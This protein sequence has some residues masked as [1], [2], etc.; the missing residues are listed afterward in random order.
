MQL[1]RRRSRNHRNGSA[2]IIAH[3]R[4]TKETREFRERYES[5]SELELKSFAETFK[6]QRVFYRNFAERFEG[7][8][9]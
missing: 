2:R 8:V 9:I 4:V 6:V 3:C 1:Q 5:K 7:V